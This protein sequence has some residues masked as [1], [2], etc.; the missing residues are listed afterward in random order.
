MPISTSSILAEG[1]NQL[2]NRAGI[3]FM[4]ASP[5]HVDRIEIDSPEVLAVTNK[6]QEIIKQQIDMSA[7]VTVFVQLKPVGVFGFVPIWDGVAEAWFVC[8]G[9]ARQYPVTMTK[10]AMSVMDIAKK[11]LRLHRIQITVRNTDKRAYNWAR[12]I[13]FQEEALMSKYGPDQV[14]YLLMTRF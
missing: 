11:S 13:G 3:F 9:K 6:P 8:S 4:P 1:L 2:G 14:D 5:A 10:Y 7:A 12:F